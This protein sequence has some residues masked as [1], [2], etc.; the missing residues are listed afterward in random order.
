VKPSKCRFFQ[1]HVTFLSHVISKKGIEPDPEKIV[2]IVRWPEPTNLTEIRSFL[3]LAPYYKNFVESF[4]EVARPLYELTRKN[5]PFEWDT[6][7]RQAFEALKARLCSAP[8]LATSTDQGDF[9]AGR[10]R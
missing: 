9:F 2:C 3:G 10:G 1:E 8:V 7:H 6:R 4:G 5:V